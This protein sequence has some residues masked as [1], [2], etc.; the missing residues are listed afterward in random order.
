MLFQQEVMEYV[1]VS[2]IGQPKD[3]KLKIGGGGG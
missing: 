3:V 1:G 2:V